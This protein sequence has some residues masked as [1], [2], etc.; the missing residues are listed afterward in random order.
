[1]GYLNE[2]LKAF[3]FALAGIR[4]FFK[5]GVHAKFHLVAAIL[6]SGLGLYCQ[7]DSFEWIS[8]LLLFALILALEAM[9]SALEAAVDLA[10]PEIDPLAKKSKDIAAGAVLL[11]SIFAVIIGVVIFY[12]KLF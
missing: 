10:Q 9:N 11:A 2:R 1:M 5:E 3:G 6:V 8:L 12:P 4:I 7:I